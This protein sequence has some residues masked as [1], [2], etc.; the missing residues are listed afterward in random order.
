[1][2]TKPLV[3]SAILKVAGRCNINCTYCYMYNLADQTFRQQPGV[4]SRRTVDAAFGWAERY[5]EATGLEDFHFSLHGGEPLLA[6]KSLIDYIADR[7]EAAQARTGRKISLSL[8][9]NGLLLD[10]EWLDLFCRRGIRFGLSIDGPREYH[11]RF[12]LTRGGEGTHRQV[13]EKIRWIQSSP[14]G[15]KSFS[16]V[17]CVLH[18]DMDG[19]RLLHYFVGLGLDGVDFLL[20]DQ[21]HLH[22][23][24]SYPRPGPSPT[25]GLVLADAYR[26]WRELDDPSFHVRKFAMIIAALFG[27]TPSLDSLGT[28]PITVFTIE[29]SG[30]V[31]PVDTLKACGHGYTKS[32][33]NIKD[34]AAA[35]VNELPLI[36]MGLHKSETLPPKCQ[37]CAFKSL[38][39]GGYLPHRFGE[40]GFE[41]ETVYCA[42]MLHLCEVIYEDVAS[43]VR[44]A[45]ARLPRPPAPGARPAPQPSS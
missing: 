44:S 14:K 31:E 16:S 39:G 30:E 34:V 18:P 11:D 22:G 23:S 45:R 20:P 41:L 9:T 10:D 13:E 28:G 12:R 5:L 24:D 7:R 19:R 36:R 42:D 3:T 15:L 21:N 26:A 40:R 2:S 6:G 35:E 17:L 33:V 25:Y 27:K 29:T 8:L 43:A 32:G 1:M 38:C 4:M 37:A